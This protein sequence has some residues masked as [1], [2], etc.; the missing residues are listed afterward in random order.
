M[1]FSSFEC[2]GTFQRITA[3]PLCR[4]D[5]NTPGGSETFYEKTFLTDGTGRGVFNIT[6]SSRV[7]SSYYNAWIN[8]KNSVYSG[9][10]NPS[11]LEY[12]DTYNFTIPSLGNGTS[13]DDGETGLTLLIH[14]SSNVI[15]GNTG[16]YYYFRVTANTITNDTSFTNCDLNCIS[17]IND[18]V[19]KVNVRSTGMTSGEGSYPLNSPSGKYFINPI[20]GA[21]IVRGS[22]KTVT[23]TSFNSNFLTFDWISNTIPFSGST[24]TL[25]P[26][27]S[28]TVC[29]YNNTGQKLDIFNSS[30][31]RNFKFYHQVRL[32]NPSNVNDFDIWASPISNFNYLGSP[33][34]PQF[35]LAY[36]YSGGNVTFS[37]STYIIG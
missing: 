14:Q 17:A 2:L 32:T 3:D 5:N 8:A 28:G 34:S 33:S 37:S 13:C 19:S 30:Y 31:N 7:I 23:A 25:I 20:P 11:T 35:E 26:S 9:N 15:T 1:Y 18:R 36:R 12:Y 29:N 21:L 16:T 24:P 10:T 22:V 4:M 27:L 6:G